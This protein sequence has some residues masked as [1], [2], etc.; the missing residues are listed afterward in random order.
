MAT[1]IYNMV[2]MIDMYI[3][4]VV[5]VCGVCGVDCDG[6][7]DGNDVDVVVVGL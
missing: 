4:S 2:V 3:D 7:C 1:C 6:N 5:E